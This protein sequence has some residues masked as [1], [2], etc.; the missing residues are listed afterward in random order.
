MPTEV[1]TKPDTET[2]KG[3]PGDEDLFSHYVLKKEIDLAI[4]E[5]RP[6]IA[7]CGK[8]WIP[9]RDPER[10]PICPDC[11]DIYDNTKFTDD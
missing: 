10:F 11:K 4:L 5:G 8:S 3:E 2:Y 1:D 9:T 7:L 6:C